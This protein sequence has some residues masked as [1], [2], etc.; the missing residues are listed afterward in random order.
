M[1][2][3]GDIPQSDHAFQ[4]VNL[5]QRFHVP[6][7]RALL[8]GGGCHRFTVR[9]KLQI[10]DLFTVASEPRYFVA[11]CQIPQRHFRVS[12]GNGQESAAGVKSYRRTVHTRIVVKGRRL[13]ECGE[14]PPLDCT[15]G[16]SDEVGFS[17]GVTPFRA[18]CSVEALQAARWLFQRTAR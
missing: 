7:L 14:F 4:L 8:P 18:V 13:L 15:V 11:A 12:A 10:G 9:R 17:V 5:A 6:E 16:A 3:R 2:F 1:T